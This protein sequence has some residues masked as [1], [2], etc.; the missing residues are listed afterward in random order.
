MDIKTIATVI[1][2][3]AVLIVLAAWVWY[4]KKTKYEDEQIFDKDCL[5]DLISNDDF[6]EWLKDQDNNNKFLNFLLEN[7]GK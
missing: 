3:I 7:L 4:M 5:A 6:K 2:G 1:I